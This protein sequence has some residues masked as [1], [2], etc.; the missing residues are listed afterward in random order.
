[1]NIS[2]KHETVADNPSIKI[3]VN[4]I[5]SRITFK[6]KTGY[7]LE[8][9]TLETMKLLGNTKS[10]ITKD[11]NCENMSHL[12]ITEV[13]LINFKIVNNDYQQNS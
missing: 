12:E 1:M 8:F 13:V 6:I 3:C 5:E 10:K 9:L 7:Y 4:K 2:K 11:E